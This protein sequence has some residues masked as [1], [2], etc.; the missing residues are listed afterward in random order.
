MSAEEAE[1]AQREGDGRKGTSE[2]CEERE[3]TAFVEKIDN[4]QEKC[5]EEY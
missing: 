3:R 5:M 2:A 1:A 4:L